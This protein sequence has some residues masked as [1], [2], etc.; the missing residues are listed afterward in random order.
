MRVLLFT[1]N[2]TK[3]PKLPERSGLEFKHI[4]FESNNL[5]DL[6]EISRFRILNFPTSLVIDEKNRVL[7]KVKGS[8][9]GKYIDK[10]IN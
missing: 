1:R 3:V 10:L 7:L 5:D 9:P 4:K 8:I 6:L 2:G